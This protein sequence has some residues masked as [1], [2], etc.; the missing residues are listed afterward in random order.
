MPGRTTGNWK[1]VRARKLA[2]IALER[3]FGAPRRK[4]ARAA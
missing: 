1:V 4:K 2:S 3:R